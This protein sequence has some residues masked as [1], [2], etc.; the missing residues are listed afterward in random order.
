M[1]YIL[2]PVENAEEISEEF[3]INSC[4]EESIIML[5]VKP[6]PKSILAVKTILCA[7]GFTLL[8]HSKFGERVWAK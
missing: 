7:N 4:D 5:H 8:K 1:P 3:I 6:D 2:S